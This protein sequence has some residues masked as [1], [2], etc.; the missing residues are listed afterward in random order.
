[1]VDQRRNKFLTKIEKIIYYIIMHIDIYSLIL[2]IPCLYSLVYD[3]KK[4]IFFSILDWIYNKIIYIRTFK[5]L[6]RL[7]DYYI[8]KIIFE[9]LKIINNEIDNPNSEVTPIIRNLYRELE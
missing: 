4:L 9:L 2:G 8:I 6:V 7:I 1:M 3:K 5:L